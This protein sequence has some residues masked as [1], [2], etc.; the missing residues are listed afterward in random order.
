MSEERDA[1]VGRA[2]A[3]FGVQPF[4]YQTF[5]SPFRE[6][7]VADLTSPVTRVRTAPVPLVEPRPFVVPA[8]GSQMATEVSLTT[9]QHAGCRHTAD[10]APPAPTVGAPTDPEGMGLPEV[11]DAIQNAVRAPV[12]AATEIARPA[13]P[14]AVEAQ[15]A[16]QWSA[17]PAPRPAPWRP[18][19]ALQPSALPHAA[20]MPE[21]VSVAAV[22]S[23]AAHL[24]RSPEPAA[25]ESATDAT[26]STACEA[27]RQG[28][29]ETPAQTLPAGAMFRVLSV[30]G[31]PPRDR[32]GTGVARVPAS[33]DPTL[34]RRL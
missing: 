22:P 13:E 4:N 19:Q 31:E 21:P 33:P 32:A 34:F 27:D 28:P 14:P 20:V 2:L 8:P 10:G 3:C 25:P 17:W 6:I 16:P 26:A 15:A 29:G 9:P 7:G 24:P 5:E 30:P 18:R 1:D 23:L 12:M 11:A